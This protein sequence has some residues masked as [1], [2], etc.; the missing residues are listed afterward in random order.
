MP[1]TNS[2]LPLFVAIQAATLSFASV[3]TRKE[4]KREKKEKRN[5]FC[6]ETPRGKIE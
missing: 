1:V 5:E 3:K 2:S 4:K 6:F